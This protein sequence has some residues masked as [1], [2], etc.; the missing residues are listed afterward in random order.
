MNTL[1]TNAPV[2]I[3]NFT[4]ECSKRCRLKVKAQFL[5]LRGLLQKH[6]LDSPGKIEQANSWTRFQLVAHVIAFIKDLRRQ[7]KLSC[8]V[9]NHIVIS[10]EIELDIIKQNIEGGSVSPGS[11]RGSGNSDSENQNPNSNNSNEKTNNSSNWKS[12]AA[13]R[14]RLNRALKRLRELLDEHSPL[15]A[16]SRSA[17]RAG[18]LDATSDYIEQ[19]LMQALKKNG[20]NQMAGQNNQIIEQNQLVG[21]NII[22]GKNQFGNLGNAQ[23][24]G[25][26]QIGRSLQN[27]QQQMG[28][29]MQNAQIIH[30]HNI[31]NPGN[32]NFG[33]NNMNLVQQHQHFMQSNMGQNTQQI[34]R[35]GLYQQQN[36]FQPALQQLTPNAFMTVPSSI[37][38]TPN[39]MTP[40]SMTS[41][42]LTPKTITSL[43]YQNA[44]LLPCTPP[45][46]NNN[47]QFSNPHF[48]Q[49]F[50]AL[51]KPSINSLTKPATS[52]PRHPSNIAAPLFNTNISPLIKKSSKR[53]SCGSPISVSP[54]VAE[55]KLKN[56]LGESKN[57]KIWRPYL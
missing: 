17:S 6:Y 42:P 56:I 28:H 12:C 54:I 47:A 53:R 24:G 19:L 3:G 33:V 1:A 41:S 27:R 50:P 49:F 16:A 2:Q 51:S 21:Q 29:G 38:L 43:P 52:T 57:S 10:P 20:Q 44:P 22:A 32:A 7:L 55:R 11:G 15:I 35:P 5:R 48:N 9:A 23:I 46:N 8:A 26:P 25:N 13:Y 4:D 39:S 18:L 31:Q 45:A 30:H 40:N 37:A 14:N 36:N 34:I